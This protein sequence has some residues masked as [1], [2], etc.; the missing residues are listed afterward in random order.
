MIAEIL[1]KGLKFSIF[2]GR[3]FHSARKYVKEIN[4]DF[5]MV[6]QNGALIMKPFSG[7]ILR[8][9]PL[10]EEIARKIINVARERNIFFI[11][12]TSFF[13]VRD[14]VIERKYKGVFE[15]Y[16]A[17]NSWRL[18]FSDDVLKYMRDS[19]AEVA[20]IGKEEGILEVVKDVERDH[21][22]EF[23]GVKNTVRDDE[24]FYEFFGPDST[25]AKAL[26][27]LLGH[28]GTT[29]DRVAFIG[30]SY[31]D[32]SLMEIVGVPI[33]MGNSPEDVKNKAK[34]ITLSNDEAG[35]AYAIDKILKGEWVR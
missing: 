29:L 4:V 19:V 26:E 16:L 27:F 32:L 34:F 8:I 12:F 22:G 30:D 31:N 14:M 13:E 2:T 23:T 17:A 1:R 3:N 15:D 9:S 18:I 20:L 11:L 7:E 21:L 25:K 10:K 33:A 6:F 24:V 35:V 5:P 28:F